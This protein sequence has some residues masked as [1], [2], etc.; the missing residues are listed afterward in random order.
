[1]WLR[2]MRR[3]LNALELAALTT[4]PDGEGKRKITLEIAEESIQQRAVLYD[5]SGDQHYDVISAFIK[6]C[7]VLIRMRL[8]IGSAG[9]WLQVKILALSPG[10]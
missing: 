3:A 9:C 8:Y 5:K 4:A 6:A 1:M 2:V 10:A 7:G